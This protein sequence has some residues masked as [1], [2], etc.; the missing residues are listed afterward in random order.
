MSMQIVFAKLEGKEVSFEKG[1]RGVNLTAALSKVVNKYFVENSYMEED[2]EVIYKTMDFANAKNL[3]IDIKNAESIIWNEI[4]ATKGNT[5]KDE[6]IMQ[7]RDFSLLKNQ[8][9]EMLLQECNA[10]QK[11]LALI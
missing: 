10:N 9:I 6:K 3:L 7:F 8:V 2:E 1:N 4:K 11:V 5:L